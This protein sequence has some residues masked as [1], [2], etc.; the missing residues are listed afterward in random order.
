[1]QLK[2]FALVGLQF[3]GNSL[4]K[5]IQTEDGKQQTAHIFVA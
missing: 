5:K 1:L 4:G 3:D 2:L